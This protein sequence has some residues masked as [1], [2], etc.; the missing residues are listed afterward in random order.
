M[1][2]VVLLVVFLVVFGFGCTAGAPEKMPEDFSF[3]YFFSNGSW[4]ETHQ[5][6]YTLTVAGDGQSKVRY[7]QGHEAKTSSPVVAWEKEF[8]FSVEE[9]ETIYGWMLD[10]GVF[11]KYKNIKKAIPQAD[12][13]LIKAN[14]ASRNYEFGYAGDNS[15]LLQMFEK[16]E[17]IIPEHVWLYINEE[18]QKQIN[19]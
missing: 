8:G 14:F 17:H 7:V 13:F 12:Y 16:I 9:R 11:D 2:K 6:E 3:S 15:E 19:N 18:A 4:P 5:Y 10:N 1:K